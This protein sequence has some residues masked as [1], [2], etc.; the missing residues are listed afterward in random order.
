MWNPKEN[1]IKEIVILASQIWTPD[2]VI[3]NSADS[4]IFLNV[5]TRMYALVTY[6]GY[7]FLI[8]S[9]PGLRTRCKMVHVH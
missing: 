7:V 1:G 2:T 9:A 4:N 6:E 8:Y 5:P 3:L